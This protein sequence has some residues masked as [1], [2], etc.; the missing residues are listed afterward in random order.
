MKRIFVMFAMFALFG[1]CS[2]KLAPNSQ[3]KNGEIGTTKSL[4][5]T[6]SFQLPN[7][8]RDISWSGVSAHI[9]ANVSNSVLHYFFNNSGSEGTER[10]VKLT[11]DL[12]FQLAA[13]GQKNPIT[14]IQTSSGIVT[15]AE[16]T[17]EDE[18]CYEYFYSLD[19]CSKTK[20]KL[21]ANFSVDFKNNSNKS[22]FAYLQTNGK[23]RILMDAYWTKNSGWNTATVADILVAPNF[24]SYDTGSEYGNANMLVEDNVNVQFN[25]EIERFGETHTIRMNPRMYKKHSE[26]IEGDNYRV[27]N[28]KIAH[29]DL[30]Q[31]IDLEPESYES[32]HIIHYFNGQTV[33]FPAYYGYFHIIDYEF[34][35]NYNEYLLSR[36]LSQPY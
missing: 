15:I 1:G 30:D 27:I 18:S 7:I 6:H 3:T 16:G 13:S 29:M 4:T 34:Q 31:T 9:N 26:T 24:T 14:H 33:Y 36:D 32:V 21:T 5:H 22:M 17:L 10:G 28:H 19:Q 20:Y 25:F 12:D 11:M 8:S 35:N 23:Y 2:K